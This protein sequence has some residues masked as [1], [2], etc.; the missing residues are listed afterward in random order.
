MNGIGI[1][2]II[3]IGRFNFLPIITFIGSITYGLKILYT[4][5][6]DFKTFFDKVKNNSKEKLKKTEEISKPS[7][8]VN[9]D[10]KLNYV[11][12][13]AAGI[14]LISVFLP[15]IG[16]STSGS[17]NI[18]GYSSS[19]STGTITVSGINSTGGGFGLLF[20]ITG[21]IL[22]YK[23][24]RW[25]FIAG[26]LGLFNGLGYLIG[27]FELSNTVS[28]KSDYSSYYGSYGG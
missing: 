1:L 12:I 9:S 27:W 20:A 13:V 16:I 11:A 7:N 21:G 5:N 17:S 22:A 6:E 19:F 3:S 24:V 4:E 23:N 14:A 18:A 26:V 10:P 2:N 8:P 15:W 28:F 25:A